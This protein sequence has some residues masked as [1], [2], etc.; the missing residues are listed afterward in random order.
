MP[1]RK[2]FDGKGAQNSG[3]FHTL[4]VPA[5]FVVWDKDNGVKL[6]KIDIKRGIFIALQK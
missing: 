2:G 6:F 5:L 4:G 1:P 3:H